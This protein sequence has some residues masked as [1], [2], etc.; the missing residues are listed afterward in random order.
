MREQFRII[1][2]FPDYEVSNL[3]RVRTL[4]RSIRYVH[5]VTREE[6]FR[7]TETRFLKVQFNNRTGYKFHQLYLN[8]KMYNRNIHT[9]VAEAFMPKIEGFDYVNHIDGN[10]HNNILSNLERCTNEYNHEHATS[11]GLK[12]SGSRV[13]T[14]KLDELSVLAIKRMLNDGVSKMQI[15]KWFNVSRA[16][17]SLIALGKTWKSID[18]NRTKH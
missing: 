17:I 4:S 2:S 14:S 9:L 18:R 15:S 6:H 12:A 8:K 13:G 10:K 16:S 3:G 1:P 7:K 11:T 5:A